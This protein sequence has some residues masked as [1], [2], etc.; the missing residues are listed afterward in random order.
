MKM[1][2]LEMRA[3]GRAYRGD[4][5]II[6]NDMEMICDEAK[7]RCLEVRAHANRE[8]GIRN[9]EWAYTDMRGPQPLSHG[10]PSDKNEMPRNACPRARKLRR[11]IQDAKCHGSDM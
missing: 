3:H 11:Y 1:R 5:Y 2:C 4:A 7:M 8:N 9:A 10:R 6:Q